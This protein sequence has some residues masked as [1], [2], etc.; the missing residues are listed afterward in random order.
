MAGLRFF[1][2]IL[3]LLSLLAAAAPVRAQTW[4]ERLGY[5]ADKKVLIL[6]ADGAGLV[7]ESN[8]AAQDALKAGQVQSVGLMMPAPWGLDFA[9]QAD[10]EKMS[11]HDIGLALT[12]TS[13]Y[14][15]YRWKPVSSD[16][17]VPSLVDADGYLWQTVTQVASSV[18]T[19]E[20]DREIH[21][22]IDRA[23]TAGFE[24]SHLA[25]HMGAL[26]WRPDLLAVYLQ[27]AHKRW[28]PAVVVELTPERIKSFRERGYPLSDEV[29]Q[30]IAKYPL[31]KLDDL[32]FSPPGNSYEQ[33]RERM[34]QLIKTLPP[35]LTQIVFHPAAGGDALKQITRNWQ[36][37]VWDAQLLADPELKE[38]L[39]Q[40]GV[41][42]T[43]W[44]EIMHRFDERPRAPKRG[45]P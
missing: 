36:D 42:L 35:G 8:R 29:I 32:R 34:F 39:Q 5:P 2:T 9:R 3:S 13:E 17:Q 45:E 15:N 20:V 38:L 37:R 22:Q 11:K 21:A 10:A 16:N 12:L 33:K 4:A 43:N 44:K 24:P 31:P 25:P 14:A 30:L 19:D 26:V 23:R 18:K 6:Y 28:I 1:T 41:V 40:E 27:A 7:Y